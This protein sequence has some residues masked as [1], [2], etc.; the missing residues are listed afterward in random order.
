MKITGPGGAKGVGGAKRNEKGKSTGGGAFAKELE[1]LDAAQDAQGSFDSQPVAAVG[2]LLSL[3]QVE[4]ATDGRSRGLVE[5]YGESLLD[6]L[7]RLRDGLL[8]G[9]VD[10]Q[11]LQNL[12][13]SMRAERRRSEDPKL[14]AIIEEIELRAE[15]ELAK[16]TRKRP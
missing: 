15:V 5:N 13:Q 14:N 4:T 8:A 12:A 2:S 16:L 10:K 1:S 6:R 7:D 3:Q 11:D 9:V